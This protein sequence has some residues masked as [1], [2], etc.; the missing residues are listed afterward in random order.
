MAEK[1]P[2]PGKNGVN[3]APKF[4]IARVPF[5]NADGILIGSNIVK[6]PVP[7]AVPTVVKVPGR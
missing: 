5:R 3:G 4:I 6:L 7:R 2:Q 1:E